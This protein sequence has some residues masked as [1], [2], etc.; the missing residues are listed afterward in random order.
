MTIRIEELDSASLVNKREK[1]L[2]IDELVV[3]GTFWKKKKAHA[4]KHTANGKVYTCPRIILDPSLNK[5][6]ARSYRTLRGRVVLKELE[7]GQEIS[8]KDGEVIVLFF[9]EETQAQTNTQ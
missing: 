8:R 2:D 7:D 5:F 1:H 4:F 3:V 9:P 6:V